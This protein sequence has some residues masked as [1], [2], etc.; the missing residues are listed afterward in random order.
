MQQYTRALHRI[1]QE[2]Q[3]AERQIIQDFPHDPDGP[4][5]CSCQW[6][7]YLFTLKIER[8]AKLKEVE[9]DAKEKKEKLKAKL[10]LTVQLLADA[11]DR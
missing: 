2:S 3:I 5:T 6:Y 7:D 4:G 8:L 11:Y 10:T 1:D 9:D